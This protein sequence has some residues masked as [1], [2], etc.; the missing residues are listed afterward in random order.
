MSPRH[1]F[2]R[3]GLG[4]FLDQPGIGG[5]T[6]LTRAIKMGQHDA[7]EAMQVSCRRSLKRP[8]RFRF[9]VL[10]VSDSLSMQ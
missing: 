9:A 7:V 2:N 3:L 6:Y 8:H 5:E 4:D 1:S 10:K